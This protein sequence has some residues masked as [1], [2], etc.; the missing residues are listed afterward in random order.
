MNEATI[1]IK[2]ILEEWITIYPGLSLRYCFEALTELHTIKVNPAAFH[3]S[4]KSFVQAQL[5]LMKAVGK[6][7]PEH[8]I[9][10]FT[11][12]NLDHLLSEDTITIGPTHSKVA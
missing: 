1:F 7:F 5:E 4:N 10:Y 11:D 8:G 3:D 9:V 12:S 2:N 6:L